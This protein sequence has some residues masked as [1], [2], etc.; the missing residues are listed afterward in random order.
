MCSDMMWGEGPPWL[1]AIGPLM[2][3][4]S[5]GELLCG[6][7]RGWFLL[8]FYILRLI[9]RILLSFLAGVEYFK[10]GFQVALGLLVNYAEPLCGV[11]PWKVQPGTHLAWTRQALGGGKAPVTLPLPPGQLLHTSPQDTGVPVSVCPA[12]LLSTR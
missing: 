7:C 1:W 4:C 5:D 2:C 12:M 3:V 8:V 11:P 10:G 6:F 9:F